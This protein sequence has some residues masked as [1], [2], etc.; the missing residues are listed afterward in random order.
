MI[1]P[2]LGDAGQKV[3]AWLVGLCEMMTLSDVVARHGSM[4]MSYEERVRS[5]LRTDEHVLRQ[6][7][8]LYVGARERTQLLDLFVNAGFRVTVLEA[9]GPNC[10]LLRKRS[11][12]HEVIQGNINEFVTMTDREWDVVLWWHGPEHVE[13]S[14]LRR[15]LEGIKK[16]A[17]YMVVLGCPWGAYPQGPLDDNPYEVHVSHLTPEFFHQFGYSTETLGMKDTMG[18]NITAWWRRKST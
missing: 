18:S 17:R 1:I 12:I 9:W 2:E 7:T 13:L 16:I 6:K 14:I 8:L 15:T 5:L 10:E 4:D 11:D 3:N